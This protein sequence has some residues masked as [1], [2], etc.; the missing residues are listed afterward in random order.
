MLTIIILSILLVAVLYKV[1][2]FF[3]SIP[4]ILI[5]SSYR[6]KQALDTQIKVADS[7][8]DASFHAQGVSF[9]SKIA[10]FVDD[11][12]NLLLFRWV[13]SFPSLHVRMFIFRHIFKIDIADRVCIYKGLEVRNPSCLHIGEGTCIGDNAHLD[14][15]KG[16]TLGE[17][18]NLSSNVQIYTLQ[19]DYRDPEFA[20]N[21]D[22]CGPVYVGARAWLGPGCI[23]LPGTTIGEGA[24]VGAGAVVTKDVPAYSVFAGVP[25][26]KIAD[27][28]QDLVYKLGGTH[29]HFL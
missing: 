18:V 21:D 20:C 19:H 17:N 10:A 4:L 28:P 16:L 3:I 11:Y 5:Y 7:S 9:K 13:A 23:I 27:R 15:R 1:L 2:L 6:R 26:R 8:S 14:A 24:V 29:R 22:H 25:A 12:V